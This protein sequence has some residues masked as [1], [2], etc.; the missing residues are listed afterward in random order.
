MRKRGVFYCCDTLSNNFACG[1]HVKPLSCQPISPISVSARILLVRTGSGIFHARAI[2]AAQSGIY[3]RTVTSEAELEEA[4]HTESFDLIIHDGRNTTGEL[5]DFVEK[6]RPNQQTTPI[7]LLCEKPQLDV[8]VKAIRLGVRD[9]F[10][11]PVNLGGLFARTTELLQPRLNG[12]T[13]E[14]AQ[15]YRSELTLFLAGDSKDASPARSG[16][17][18]SSDEKELK[19]LREECDRINRQFQEETERRVAAETSVQGR[20]KE[21]DERSQKLARIE[22]ELSTGQK[23]VVAERDQLAAMMAGIEEERVRLAAEAEALSVREKTIEPVRVQLEKERAALEEASANFEAETAGL[24][25]REKALARTLGELA[26]REKALA[27]A[28]QAIR[29][30][31]ADLEKKREALAAAEATA[32]KVDNSG[33]TQPISAASLPLPAGAAKATPALQAIRS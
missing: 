8:I 7:V 10:H 16:A 30:E 29:T 32:V 18:N 12:R 17:K 23:R 20:Q 4:L 6:T 33:V 3:A 24:T 22:V 25:Q 2:V 5:L 11:S 27:E 19:S 26:G 15:H 28:Q 13:A 9:L 21:F 14:I 1:P 31:T